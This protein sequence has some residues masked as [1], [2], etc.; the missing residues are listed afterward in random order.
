MRAS[1]VFLLLTTLAGFQAGAAT[2]PDVVIDPGG[3]PPAAIKAIHDAVDAITRLTEDQDGG[4]VWRLRRRAHAATLSALQTQGYFSPVVT[5]EVG[6]DVGGETWDIIIEPGERTQV[7]AVDLQFRGQI[8]RPE[9]APRLEKLKGEW[10]LTSGQ[11]FINA[12]WSDAKD[13]LL[14]DISRKDFY[15]A[16][17]DHTRATVIAEQARADLAISVD[18][19]P[20]VRLGELKVLGLRRVPLKLVRRTVDYERGEPYD[21]Q[22]LD[23]WQQALN[24][25]SFFRGAF[26]TLQ[27][28]EEYRRVLEDDSVE[29]PLQVRVTEALA[30]RFS[31]SVG[32]DSDH[33]LRV[34][35]LYRQNVVFGQPVWMETGAGVD[36]RRQRAFLDIHLPPDRDGYNDAVGVLAS[37]TD[38]EGVRTRRF[39]LGWKRL[40]ERK[41]AGDSRVD[42]QVRTGI[43]L[44]HDWTRNRG[45]DKYKVPTLTATWQWLRRDVDDIYDPREG[46]LVEFGL[47]A[48][49]TL[50]RGEPFGRTSVRAQKW[51]PVGDHD[52]VTLRGE[53]GKV[54]SRT[55]RLPEDFGYR[56]GGARSIRGY[57]F[58]S[59][60]VERGDAIVAAQALVA[61]GV[62]YTHYF[63]PEL[64][65][66]VFVD[67][68]DAAPSF[69]QL[70]WHLG[71][72]VGLSVRTPAGPFSVDLAYGQYDRRLRLHFSLGIAF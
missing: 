12:D 64:G 24:E 66:N 40:Q 28:D 18:S 16:R 8:L 27:E 15:F 36:Y 49:L 10:S 54:W 53:V 59:L 68:G 44:A 17:Y 35:G 69:R 62:E 26:V 23:D 34:E 7:G 5:L 56:T 14:E 71:Y 1:R 3:V 32:A 45:A 4:E 61:L 30:R 33:G 55:D 11:T 72:G 67:A 46:H 21:Q 38:I 20:Q 13:A 58:N 31:A 9:Y 63:T 43:V 2:A 60:G 48:G 25:T 70:S 50:D 39:G 65:M 19:G 22:R 41:A 29:L 6:R 47:G 37:N 42:Y 52:V 57:R 51:W